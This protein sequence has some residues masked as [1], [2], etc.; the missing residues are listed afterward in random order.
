MAGHDELYHQQDCETTESNGPASAARKIVR[1][2]PS[3]SCRRRSP[4]VP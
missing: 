3:R 4:S 1:S 2:G